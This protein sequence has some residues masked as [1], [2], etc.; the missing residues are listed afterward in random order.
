MLLVAREQSVPFR[1]PQ[2]LDD[3]PARAA[4]KAL[5][6][7]NNL[8]VAAHWPVGALEIAV[9]DEGQIVKPLAGGERKARDGFGLVHLAIAEDSP[10]V[11]RVGVGETTML[12]VAEETSLVDRSD[13]PDA[14]RARRRLP[15]V[16]HKPG[17][18]IGAQTSA[19]DLLAVSL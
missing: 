9:D 16:R 12:E 7:R 11:S 10:N 3:V 13:G 15:E 2:H 5:Q 14:H 4:E 17:M 18:G 19:I 8:T 6:F 1:A